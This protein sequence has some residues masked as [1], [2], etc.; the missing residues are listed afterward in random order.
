M[1]LRFCRPLFLL[2]ALIL[3]GACGGTESQ[4]AATPVVTPETTP[5]PVTSASPVATPSS[6]GTSGNLFVNPSFENGADPWI[7]LTTQAWGTPFR[8]TDAAAH[9]G[10]HSALL[11]L[12]ADRE[13]TGAKVFG[14]VQEVSPGQFP[15]LLSG[16]YRVEDWTRGTDKQYLQFVVI[17]M[18]PVG[19]PGDFP[20]YQIRYLLAGINEPPFQIANAHFVFVN[21]EEP[22]TGKWV[23]FERNIRED[24]QQLWGAVPQ[25]YSGIRILFEVRYDDKQAGSGLA[26]ADVLYD[27]LYVGP[28]AAN[29][30][31]PE[32]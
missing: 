9:S 27:D 19:M 30:N 3:V 31:K 26:K 20:N 25:A 32:P 21:E 12:R 15:E 10:K 22:V 23:Y 24:F 2:A 4:P 1:H 14:V 11:E 28:A 7:S 29:P 18:G 6:H 16:Y 5:P 13:D 17:V 8:V